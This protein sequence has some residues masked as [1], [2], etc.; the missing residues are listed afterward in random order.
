MTDE[1]KANV[2]REDDK[3]WLEGPHSTGLH[4]RLIASIEG[5]LRYLGCQEATAWITEIRDGFAPVGP[6]AIGGTLSI[7]DGQAVGAQARA[8]I[9]SDDSPIE[10]V[11]I[12][13]RAVIG[14]VHSAA[15]GGDRLGRNV[16]DGGHCRNRRARDDE[17][18]YN[19]R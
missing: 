8:A 16:A 14:L 7:G 13:L 1:L 10:S 6:V 18:V 15:I 5:C 2:R 4:T 17:P 11:P 9:A 3:V 19:G 12:G